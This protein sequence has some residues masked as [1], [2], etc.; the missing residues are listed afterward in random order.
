MLCVQVLV[1]C[2][3]TGPASA[4]S[5]K[6]DLSEERITCIYMC[7][8]NS[9]PTSDPGGVTDLGRN[10]YISYLL[11]TSHI[12]TNLTYCSY[13]LLIGFVGILCLFDIILSTIST[14]NTAY[15]ET[16]LLLV[17]TTSQRAT[18][19][20]RAVGELQDR[21]PTR[22]ASKKRLHSTRATAR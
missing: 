19:R 18:A 13:L 22:E 9:D 16:Y 7:D 3:E 6:A 5:L 15:Y 17:A 2:Q 12:L 1:P 8:T 20:Q 10:L 11:N 4:F 21:E 14:A